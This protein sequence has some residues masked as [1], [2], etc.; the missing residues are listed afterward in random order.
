MAAHPC[1]V[2]TG[3]YTT[4]PT[5]PRKT[6]GPSTATRG[7]EDSQPPQPTARHGRGRKP[8]PP[9]ARRQV[10]P[11]AYNNTA[12]SEKVASLVSGGAKGGNLQP[13]FF[14]KRKRT[15]P[16]VR[17]SLARRPELAAKGDLRTVRDRPHALGSG[18]RRVELL[19]NRKVPAQP[20]FRHA[21]GQVC[22]DGDHSVGSGTPAAALNA[23]PLMPFEYQKASNEAS[24]RSRDGTGARPCRQPCRPRYR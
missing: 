16:C 12:P 6:A 5:F 3:L 15:P 14:L 24:P 23:T 10:G 7:R 17:L 20:P 18:C 21:R 8:V 13:A 4:A 11:G 1:L 9:S 19:L 2:I 22:G